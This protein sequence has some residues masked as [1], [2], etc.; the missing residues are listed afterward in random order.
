MTTLTRA[1]AITLCNNLESLVEDL[2]ERL[3]VDFAQGILDKAISMRKRITESPQF[4]Q[5]T[6]GMDR[7]LRNMWSGVRKWDRKGEYNTQMFYGLNTV[8]Q[9]LEEA[10]I[11]VA[12]PSSSN[13]EDFHIE[14]RLPAGA[15]EALQAQA[16]ARQR[17]DAPTPPAPSPTHAKSN[18]ASAP[19]ASDE[20]LANFRE[21]CIATV[22]NQA[23]Q[24]QIRVVESSVIQHGDLGELLKK[25]S[26][27]RT[28]Q[29]LFA[30]FY[31]GKVAGVRMVTGKKEK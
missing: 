29:L 6:E 9:E 4:P 25:T 28:Q 20:D 5:V 7:A 26:S 24:K 2:S 10:E 15:L 19:F 11:P 17:R 1:E 8:M 31:A 3:P 21:S 16:E 27:D 30:A 18:S 12:P 23:Y 14:D 22:L 13:P